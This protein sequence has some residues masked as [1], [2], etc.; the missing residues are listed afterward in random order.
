MAAP[1]GL[2]GC[3]NA[4]PSQLATDVQLIASGLAAAIAAVAAVP[5]VP[6]VTMNQLQGYLTTIQTDAKAVA[7]ATATAATG[8]VQEIVSAVQAL[9]PI[10]LSFVPGGSTVWSIVNSALSLLPS[11]LAAIGVVGAPMAKAVY[12][13]DSARLILRAAPVM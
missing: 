6:A 9:A 10:A 8:T 1:I 11:L 2:A 5:G 3:A 12:T 13:P 4:T 7:A